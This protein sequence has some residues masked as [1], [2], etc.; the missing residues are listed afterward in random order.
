MPALNE[1]FYRKNQV[2][3]TLIFFCMAS[4]FVYGATPDYTRNASMIW[5]F[6]II[7]VSTLVDSGTDLSSL[8][9]IPYSK[10]VVSVFY[11][12]FVAFSFF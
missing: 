5:Q 7:E 8:P 12:P 2:M 1:M 6:S 11:F 3:S 10:L 9:P 4:V